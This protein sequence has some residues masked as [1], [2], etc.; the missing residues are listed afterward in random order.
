[1][2]SVK[3]SATIRDVAKI[4]GTSPATVCRVIR[5]KGYPVTDE[6]RRRVTEAIQALHYEARPVSER[7]PAKRSK[8]SKTAAAERTIGVLLPN[9]TN[10]FYQQAMLGIER[11]AQSK[12]YF[13]FSC[14]TMRDIQRERDYLEAMYLQGI[15]HVVISP[16]SDNPDHILRYQ[17]KGLSFVFLEQKVSGIEASRIHFDFYKGANMAV[18]HLIANG[19]RRIAFATT[20]L[21]RWGRIQVYKGYCNALEQAGVG[22]DERLVFHPSNSV[23][24][25]SAEE[26]YD[27]PAG[28]ELGKMLAQRKEEFTGLVCINDIT[29]AGVMLGLK[30][31]G[32]SIPEDLSLVSFDDIP[33][34][35][36][37][38]PELTTIRFP[39]YEAGM[40]AANLLF[41]Q[42]EGIT[43]SPLTMKLEPT[44]VIRNTVATIGQRLDA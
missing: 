38:Q 40:L 41:D 24:Q 6:L 16:V 18:N 25:E 30:S 32:F 37:L 9:T 12:G 44:L 17:Q 7:S 14:N 34:A 22:F 33:L 21:T 42:I 4:A 3:K 29:A 27:F 2:A 43:R 20:P 13:V 36:M 28:V 5:D 11:V 26:G 19:H 35:V 23:E 39:T 1:M 15:C 31:S 8:P 10:P